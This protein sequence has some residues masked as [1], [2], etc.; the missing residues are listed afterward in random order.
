MKLEELKV[1]DRVEIVNYG[2]QHWANKLAMDPVFIE[3]IKD[4]FPVLKENDNIIIY[5]ISSDL[6][7]CKGTIT[8]VS[9]TQGV[10]QYAL[11][12][13]G[14]LRKTAWYDRGQL[15]KETVAEQ[16]RFYQ[17]QEIS[18]WGKLKKMIGL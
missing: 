6:V 13:D 12:L 2:S 5:D 1:G 14:R 18:L 15:Q 8:N 10:A 11:D 16:M 4:S 9:H 17:Q 3:G 7:G